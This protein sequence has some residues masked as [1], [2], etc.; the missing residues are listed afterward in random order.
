MDLMPETGVARMIDWKSISD[1]REKYEAYLCSREWALMRRKVLDRSRGICEKCKNAPVE[2]VHHLTYI[3]KYQEELND[4]MGVCRD[5]HEDI[6][7]PKEPI[8]KSEIDLVEVIARARERHG[9]FDQIRTAAKRI[10]TKLAPRLIELGVKTG[11]AVGSDEMADLEELVAL[12]L[13]QRHMEGIQHG[14]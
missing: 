11:T 12:K 14:R 10:S 8:D 9:I 7:H 2:H 5:C 1:G 4:L 13:Y 6:H 3:R